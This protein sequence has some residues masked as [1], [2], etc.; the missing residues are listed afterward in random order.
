MKKFQREG[1]TI[2]ITAG[3]SYSSGDPVVLEDRVGIATHDAENG[4][5]LEVLLEGVVEDLAKETTDSISVGEKVYWDAGDSNVQN[6]AD[7][8][9]NKPLGWAVE[10]AATGVTSI[11]V[12][13]GA[14]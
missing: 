13:L 4:D 2:T 3:T 12:K 8:G 10:D 1:K 7:S 14:Y 5:A 9:T 11:A 6:D